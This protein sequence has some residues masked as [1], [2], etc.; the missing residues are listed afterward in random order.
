MAQNG[1]LKLHLMQN[2]MRTDIAHAQFVSIYKRCRTCAFKITIRTLAEAY[3][4]MLI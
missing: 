2:L 3:I 4:E 1:A